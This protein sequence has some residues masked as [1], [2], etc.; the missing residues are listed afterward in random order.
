MNWISVKEKLP[1]IGNE[2]FAE[3]AKGV[4]VYFPCLNFLDVKSNMQVCLLRRNKYGCHPNGTRVEVIEW[5]SIDGSIGI[6]KSSHW[7]ELPE[8]P[9][10]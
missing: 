5:C 3:T 2:D 4:L 9:N 8:K 7:C 10:E 6:D 1:I